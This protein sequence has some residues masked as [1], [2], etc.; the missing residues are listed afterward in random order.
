MQHHHKRHAPTP[1]LRYVTTPAQVAGIAAKDAK[2]RKGGPW[3][4]I[5]QSA[6]RHLAERS[7]KLR[8]RNIQNGEPW[9]GSTK[10]PMIDLLENDLNPFRLLKSLQFE[11]L[12]YCH[13]PQLDRQILVKNT[14]YLH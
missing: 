8:M 14:Y 7:A 3:F 13:V 1:A 4:G 9:R 2:R 10:T 6:K 5:G 11:R 12:S